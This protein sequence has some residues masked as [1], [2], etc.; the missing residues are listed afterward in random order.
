MN[1]H[2]FMCCECT[3]CNT[4][5]VYVTGL[6]AVQYSTWQNKTCS[7]VQ[8]STWQNK[9]YKDDKRGKRQERKLNDNKHNYIPSTKQLY[10]HQLYK[11]QA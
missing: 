11:A 4:I 2:I 1:I 6:R 5:Q 9:S 7:T 10:R 3:Y 8:Y